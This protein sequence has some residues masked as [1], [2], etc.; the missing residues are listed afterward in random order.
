MGQEMLLRRD[1]IQAQHRT[2]V[3]EGQFI[4]SKQHLFDNVLSGPER[5]LLTMFFATHKF[6]EGQ[7]SAASAY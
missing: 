6:P 5:T 2:L 1:G 7:E 3:P 4:G